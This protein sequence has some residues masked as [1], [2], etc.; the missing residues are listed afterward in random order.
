MTAPGLR[1]LVRRA[2]ASG[3][4]AAFGFALYAP[5][6]VA[7][8]PPPETKER[9]VAAFGEDNPSCREWSDGCIVCAKV[10]DGSAACST[11]GIACLP[12]AV[13]CTKSGD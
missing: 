1:P 11:V 7:Q 6:A 13:M 5:S 4:A 12:V 8:A 3:L 2:R 10:E 9:P